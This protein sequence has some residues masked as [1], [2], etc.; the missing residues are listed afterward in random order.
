[1]HSAN[2][3]GPQAPAYFNF[4]SDVMDRWAEQRPDAPAL[5]WVNAVTGNEQ[6]FTFR[7]LAALSCHAAGFL[8]LCGIQR[9]DRVL[10]M[11]PRVPQ[12]WIAMLGL[13]RLGAVP[14]PATLLLTQRQ[15]QRRHHQP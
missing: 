1:M 11:L 8:R 10:I 4:A 9:G 2:P 7:Q 13:I 5:W 3:D 12:W 14:V 15:G 6:R